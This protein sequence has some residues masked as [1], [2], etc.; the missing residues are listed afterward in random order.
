MSE[1]FY[2][3]L[4]TLVKEGKVKKDEP[5]SAHTTFKVGGPADYF[6]E[7][8]NEKELSEV[9][10]YLNKAGREY[11]IIG[12]GSN[13]LVGDRGY[14]GSVILL[15]DNFNEIR[16]DGETITAQAGA[17]LSAIANT[18]LE[19]SLTGFEF[20]A[21]IPGT[22]G[23]AVLMNAGAYGGEMADIVEC[24]EVI[25]TDGD[26]VSFSNEELKFGYRRSILQ[27]KP[28][29]VSSVTY[30]LSRGNREDIKNRMDELAAQRRS[31]QPLEYPSA[32]STFKRPEGYFAG[33]LI[34]DAGLRGY[35][36]GG[37]KV[38]EKHCGFVINYN[39]ATA[40]DIMDVINDVTERVSRH[41]SVKL[42]PEVRIVGEF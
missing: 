8:V 35:R 34:M 37:A 6:I 5:M 7:P 29:A 27:V 24:A 17:L 32:G 30:R 33:K 20:A 40:S 4:K 23:G 38:S 41:F 10:A 13:L 42:E 2:D 26:K 31:K 22:A 9:I 28:V 39:N 1:Y 3:F 18:A 11:M 12:N 14:R 36:V 21:G 15:Y 19:N 16:V 25:A